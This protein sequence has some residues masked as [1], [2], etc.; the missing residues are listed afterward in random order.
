MSLSSLDRAGFLARRSELARF[1]DGTSARMRSADGDEALRQEAVALLERLR[2]YLAETVAVSLGSVG[3]AAASSSSRPGTSGAVGL[4]PLGGGSLA[5]S[6]SSSLSAFGAM[7]LGSG[8]GGP[9]RPGTASGS[10][11]PAAGGAGHTLPPPA[12]GFL[13]QR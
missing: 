1:V 6:L 8:G 13:L 10:R 2:R 3:G 5:G 9:A 7:G 11:P 4:P 12:P